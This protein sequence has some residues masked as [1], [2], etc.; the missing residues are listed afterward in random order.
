MFENGFIKLHR[1]L[2]KWEWYKN[3]NVKAVFLHCLLMAN[4][5]PSRFEGIEVPA[6]S[7]VTSYNHL[8]EQ[9]G[10]SVMQIRVA[11]K[12]LNVTQEIT[13]SS[14]AK[15]TVITVNNWN[16]YQ[17]VTQSVTSKQHSDNTQITSKQQTDNNNIRNKE[18]KEDK[19]EKEYYGS[20]E[21]EEDDGFFESWIINDEGHKEFIDMKQVDTGNEF[22]YFD[23]AGNKYITDWDKG[24]RLADE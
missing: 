10:L 23:R 3:T 2:L 4:F 6:G 17:N 20:D 19:E 14:R 21:Q 12:H 15:Y 16:D 1:T 8:A 9:T 13:Q 18:Y 11:L 24:Y 22:V 7:F 5:E